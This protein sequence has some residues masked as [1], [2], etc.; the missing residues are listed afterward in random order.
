MKE[1]GEDVFDRVLIA[2][3]G[4]IAVRVIRACRELG[5]SPVAVFSTGEENALHVTM[6]DDAFALPETGRIPY[7]EQQA[8]IDI[9]VR[10]GC[11]AVHPGYGFLA[12]NA[13]FA[14]SCERAGL[15]FVGPSPDSIRSMGDKIA[16][17]E[18]AIKAGVPV[19]PGS[20]GEIG[21]SE[22]AQ[23]WAEANGY[24]VAIKASAGG[25]GRGFRVAHSPE[26]FA[27]AY[28]GSTGE[29]ERYFSNPTVY[30]EHYLTRPRHVE[31]QVFADRMGSAVWLGE[32]DCSIQRRHQKLVEETPSP[33]VDADLRERLGAAAVSLAK[34]VGYENAGTVEFMVTPD[35]DFFFLEMNTRIQVEHTI[36][37]EATGI[38]MVKEQFRVASGEPLSFTQDD[39]DPRGAAIQCRINA[40]DAGLGFK[41]VPGMVTAFRPPEGPGIRVDTAIEAGS[42]IMPRFDSLIA[43]LVAWGRDRDE[44]VAR[45]DRALK[46]FVIEGVPSTIPFHIRVMESPAFIAGD[47]TTSFLPENPDVIPPASG[48]DPIS[49]AAPDPTNDVVVEVNGR[50]LTVKLPAGLAAA[51]AAT[52]GP[53]TGR[54][55]MGDR[56]SKRGGSG[57]DGAEVRSPIQG[58][59]VRIGVEPGATV[60]AGDL[61]CVV[62]AMKMENEVMA[63]KAGKIGT[64][65]VSSGQSVQV[66]AILATIE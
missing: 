3:R 17:R 51:T 42:E 21:S 31:V 14:E 56:P 11:Q 65:P 44:A 13:G 62:E 45:M 23:K 16:A 28:A 53:Q 4:E 20:D 29:A 38:D 57:G 19:V 39:I 32:R 6:A 48:I 25:G 66:G 12:E 35:K 2:N 7:L 18:I 61:V 41:P 26:E 55:K 50:R 47:T 37:E 59:I 43:K 49:G 10:A 46:E 27:E 40:E 60:K 63:H 34:A 52:K 8:I 36:T 30:L 15:V 9:A 1:Q 22:E 58:T 24:P 5:I 54:A 64:I 33:A